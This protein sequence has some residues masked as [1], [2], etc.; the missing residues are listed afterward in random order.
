[1]LSFPR[2]L[3]VEIPGC[4]NTRRVR[5]PRSTRR[6]RSV[7]REGTLETVRKLTGVPINYLITVDFRGFTR[8][9]TD[10]GGVFMDVDRRYFN[11]NARARS[12][13]SAIDLQPGYQRL[14]GDDGARLRPLPAHRLRP[15]PERAPAGVREGV[16]AAGRGLS[17]AFKLPG[18][19]NTITRERRG[20]RRRRRRRSRRRSSSGTPGSSTSFR[21]GTSSSSADRGLSSE[22]SGT[23]ELRR[24][25]GRSPAS[26][27]SSCTPTSKPARRR[28]PS[29]RAGSRSGSRGPP[30]STV[31]VSVLN[32]NGVAGAAD[33]AAYLLGQ[34]GYQHRRTPATP[35][36]F[37]Y[38]QTTDLLRR[39][40]RRGR[41]RRRSEMARALRRRGGGRG[42]AR[43]RRSRRRCASSSARRS[44]DT[45]A[46]A[47][48]R[49][50]R[51][52][53]S[54]PTVENDAD[55]RD[56]ARAAAPAE[57]RTSRCSFRR[58][59]RAPRALDARRPIRVY[60]LREARAPSGS[61][62]R[63][64]RDRVLGDPADRL[65]RRADPRRTER[66]AGGSPGAS[67]ASTSTARSSTWSRSRRTAPPTG[68]RTR[69]ST[70]SRTRR[71]SRSPRA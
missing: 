52:S 29:R 50:D 26:S 3:K 30:P 55:G 38:F 13:Y 65:D 35:T 23:F 56:P 33:D 69:S 36:S 63:R 67:T 57:G 54:R 12:T 2:D 39:G 62:T 20:R 24:R 40:R 11:D 10:L 16:Q 14:N 59:A 9:S 5:R 43:A 15:L 60:R 8:S 49:R 18:I 17:A 4:K 32:G 41:R 37:D 31:T 53:A 70:R 61:S 6:S 27:T 42:A 45:L 1:M 46:P 68:C 58:C 64:L 47:P 34:R 25:R 19:V 21:A 7:A 51:R 28:R 66:D 48:R 44:T 71:C 22:N